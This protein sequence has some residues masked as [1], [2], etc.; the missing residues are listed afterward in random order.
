MYFYI[1]YIFMS[2]INY[3]INNTYYFLTTYIIITI[4]ITYNIVQ[5]NRGNWVWGIWEPCTIF[6]TL[7]FN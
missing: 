2:Y 4:Y 1:V 3:V 6:S 7:G 5:Y